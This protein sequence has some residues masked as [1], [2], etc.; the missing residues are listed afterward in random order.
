M[1]RVRVILAED[2]ET[3]R[4]GLRLL[5]ETRE[6]VEVVGEAPNGR[7]A[8]EMAT[9]MAPDVVVLDVSMPEM[10]GLAACR[11]IKAAAPDIGIVALTR[12]GDD[13][14]VQELLGAGAAGYVLKQ[15]AFD[16]LLR[17]IRA[18]AAGERYLD[19]TLASRTA[20]AYL[21]RYS[22]QPAKANISEREA[23]VL[24]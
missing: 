10:N 13:A 24:R 22:R 2:H 7:V 23:S 8:L 3:V 16:E 14:Y 15:S 12:H 4:Q 21:S 9:T 20:D 6:D 1:T 19:S 17:A 11:A 18:V 5:L